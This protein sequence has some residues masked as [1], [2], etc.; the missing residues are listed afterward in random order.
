M[1]RFGKVTSANLKI[2]KLSL[3][4]TTSNF[5]GL[6]LMNFDSKSRWFEEKNCFLKGFIAKNLDGGKMPHPV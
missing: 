4:L 1:L 2:G 6:F 3:I 5:Q